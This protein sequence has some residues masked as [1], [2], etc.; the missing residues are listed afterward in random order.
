MNAP[1]TAWH[2]VAE[3]QEIPVTS[4]MPAGRDS[5]AQLVPFQERTSCPLDPN[6][7]AWQEV[8]ETQEMLVRSLIPEGR[9]SCVQAVPL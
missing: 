1:P 4:S 6:P 8:A 7:P 3:T 9:V 5:V 2:E